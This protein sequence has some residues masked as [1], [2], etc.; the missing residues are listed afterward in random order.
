MACSPSAAHASLASGTSRCGWRSPRAG[1]H[2]TRSPST[3]ARRLPRASC[4]A[5]AHTS[6][7]ASMSM[8]FKANA[9]CNSWSITCFR[10]PRAVHF[11]ARIARCFSHQPA[12]SPWKRICSSASSKTSGSAPALSRD[13]CKYDTKKE[14]LEEVNRELEDP[15][16][17]QKPDK[18]QELGRERA[19]LSSEIDEL[20]GAGKAISDAAELLELA[21]S[22]ND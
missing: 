14:R 3:T 6:S 5:A 15:A 10:L 20:D 17:W 22:E 12:T 16:V 9:A 19:K 7:T 18:A 21:E 13:F 11:P 4:R 1:A 2:S 8:N